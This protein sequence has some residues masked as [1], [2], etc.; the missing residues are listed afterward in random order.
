MTP[1]LGVIASAKE[2]ATSYDWI[3]TAT[4]NPTGYVTLSNIPEA[5][6]Y[7]EIRATVKSDAGSD[8]QITVNSDTSNAYTFH[9]MY[10]V[11]TNSTLAG[12]T[13]MGA[14][15]NNDWNPANI[16][17]S[18]LNSDLM[19]TIVMQIS[20]STGKYK[21]YQSRSAWTNAVGQTPMDGYYIIRS[22][23]YQSTSKISSLR[24]GSNSGDFGLTSIS[25]LDLYGIKV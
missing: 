6:D 19:C 9:Q 24:F 4:G 3:A 23:Q 13:P 22:G 8:L 21:N 7:L 20:N 25:K 12:S 2:K 17:S 10:L 14:T 5:Y 11:N 15:L 1:I 18:S 16:V